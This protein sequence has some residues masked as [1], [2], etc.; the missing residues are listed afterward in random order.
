MKAICI[1]CFD[2]YE[3]RIKG[4]IEY[5][6]SKNYEVRYLISDFNHF[7]KSKYKADYGGSKQLNV[8]SY[9]KNLSISRLLSHMQYSKKVTRE[10]KRFKPDVIYCIIPPNSLVKDVGKY[11]LKNRNVKLIFDIYDMWPESFPYRTQN[12]IIKFLFSKWAMLRDEHI[13]DADR[14][15]VVSNK[16]KEDIDKKY[17]L[18]AKVLF[19]CISLGDVPNYSFDISKKIEFLYLGHVNHIT[20]IELGT[21]FLGSLS[22]SR[23]VILHI[24]GEGQNRERWISM[25][26]QVGIKTICHGVVFDENEKKKIF[27]MCNFGLNI[28][29]KEINSSMSLK[30][31]YKQR[32]RRQRNFSY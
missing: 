29:R 6:D 18:N 11:K 15:I 22:R 30:S 23:E 24:I 31:I 2:Y 4:I 27:Q 21:E 14:I 20:D 32:I 28:P 1:S 25:L 16:S 9:K 10:I 12:H 8:I 19:P 26:R 5:F 3:T 13:T 7:S 17:H